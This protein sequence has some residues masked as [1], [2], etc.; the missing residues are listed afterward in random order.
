[1]QKTKPPRDD[2]DGMTRKEQ[3]DCCAKQA[4]LAFNSL[5]ARREHQFKITMGL[6]ALLLLT[7]QFLLIKEQIRPNTLVCVGI[8]AL[9]VGIHT[10]F[11]F[12]IWLK[13]IYDEQ[14]FF[15]FRRKCAEL[16]AG[17]SYDPTNLPQR[18]PFRA[19]WRILQDG[20]SLFQIATTILL[21]AVC[22]IAVLQHRP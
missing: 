13:K 22:V 3:F 17:S 2:T 9:V 16:I 10:S 19:W 5:N 7:S 15:H 21:S 12:G 14:V 1:V 18:L 6:W 4:E 11:V 20:S 8:A